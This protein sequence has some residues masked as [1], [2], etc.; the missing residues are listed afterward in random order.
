MSERGRPRSFDRAKALEAALEVFWR[1]GYEGASL[2]DLTAAM[3]INSPSL[4][5]CFGSKEGLFRVAVE[6]YVATA[7]QEAFDVLEAAPTARAG[8]E[9]MLRLN[10]RNFTRPDRPTGCLVVLGDRNSPT[11]DDAVRAFLAQHRRESAAAMRRR[12]ERGIAEGDLPPGIDTKA[13]ADFYTTVLH[14]Q[15]MQARDGASSEA[16]HRIVDCAMTAWDALTLP[17]PVAA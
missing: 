2:T 9:A 4:Y 17:P 5:A 8:V 14:G 16:M 10:V 13:I 3:G 6:L 1:R 7:G 15:S 12:L 11:E